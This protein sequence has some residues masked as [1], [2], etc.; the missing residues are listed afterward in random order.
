MAMRILMTADTVGGVWTYALVL[1][2]A[3]QRY[4]VEIALATM[5]TP[6]SSE[7]QAAASATE[8]VEIFE[9]EYQLEWMEA[10]WDDV[11]AAGEWLLDLETRLDPDLI[12]LNNFAHGALDWRAPVLVVGHSCVYSWFEAVHGTAPPQWNRYEREVAQGLRKADSVTAPTEAMLDALERHYGPF[13]RTDAIPN[14]RKIRTS[15]TQNTEPFVLTAGRLWDKAKNIAALETVAPRLPWPTYVAGEDR[16]PDGG[17]KEFDN[18]HL[19]GQLAPDRLFGWMRRASI[20]A[21]PAR[22]EPF[23]LSALEAGLA[24]CALVL[25]DIASLREVWGDA[26]LYVP[27]DDP[28]ALQATLIQLIEDKER[29]AEM[30]HRA[31]SRARQYTPSRMAERYASL[32][33]DLLH[34]PKL[35]ISRSASPT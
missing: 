12:H 13:A 22:Y 30:A 24:G 20:F 29:R 4:D 11:E 6:L 1:A 32:Y 14:G 25:G 16:H 2:D 35:D 31:R 18:L 7:Q 9:S 15:A 27:P 34:I 10:P 23:G 33:A 3:L 17:Q 19:L 21:L 26:A 8:N 28:E 5:G